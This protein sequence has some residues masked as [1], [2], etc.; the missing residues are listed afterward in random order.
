[1][2]DTS[3]KSSSFWLYAESMLIALEIWRTTG[4]FWKGAFVFFF[5]ML[6]CSIPLIGHILC[7]VLAVILGVMAGSA[8]VDFGAPMWLGWTLGIFIVIGCTIINLESRRNL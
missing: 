7:F 3:E 6:G 2:S 8:C 5:L 1:M 4:K